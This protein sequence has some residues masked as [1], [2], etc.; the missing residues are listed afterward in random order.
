[1]KIRNL[2]SIMAAVAAIPFAGQANPVTARNVEPVQVSQT[3]PTQTATSKVKELRARANP[4]YYK[5]LRGHV[6]HSTVN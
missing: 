5:A 6:G 4:E 2:L 3:V 1:M